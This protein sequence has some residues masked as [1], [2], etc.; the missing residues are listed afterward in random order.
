MLGVRGQV[1]SAGDYF[2]A[3]LSHTL[4]LSYVA[5]EGTITLSD[6]GFPGTTQQPTSAP[7]PASMLLLGLGLMGLAGVRRKFKK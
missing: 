1:M 6:S 2:D 4:T 3:D 5:P 7:E